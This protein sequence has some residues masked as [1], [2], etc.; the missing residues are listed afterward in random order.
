M[1]WSRL[2]AFVQKKLNNNE[3]VW[4]KP[5]VRS[6]QQRAWCTTMVTPPVIARARVPTSRERVFRLLFREFN[7]RGSL[8]NRENW[9]PRKF[10]AIRYALD[11]YIKYDL[12]RDSP[13]DPNDHAYHP[14]NNAIKNHI[15]H[16]KSKLQLSKFDQEN[17]RLKIKEW[18]KSMPNT[19]DINVPVQEER[20]YASAERHSK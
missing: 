17:L 16:A 14:S 13:L 18:Q 11:H 8:V 10:P 20:C 5:A 6:I 7:F 4:S 9:L 1:I 12:C 19:I 2:E 3:L 15:F